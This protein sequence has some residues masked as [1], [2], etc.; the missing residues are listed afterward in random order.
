MDVPP[1]VAVMHLSEITVKKGGVTLVKNQAKDERLKSV[2]KTIIR[3]WGKE[4]ETLEVVVDMRNSIDLLN[5]RLSYHA[6]VLYPNQRNV[7][8]VQESDQ[9]VFRHPDPCESVL[10][11]QSGLRSKGG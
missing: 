10:F 2:N 5:R 11:G 1:P 6:H 9:G 8:I 3:V 4:G 7:T